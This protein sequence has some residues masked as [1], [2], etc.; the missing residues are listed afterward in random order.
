[1]GFVY[2]IFDIWSGNNAI[3]NCK[4]YCAALTMGGN[5]TFLQTTFANYFNQDGGRG[6]QPCVH[7]DNFDGTDSWPFIDSLFF[8]NCIIDGSQSGE[9]EMDIRPNT[10]NPTPVCKVT[11]CLIK[12]SIP[13]NT[14]IVNTNNVFNGNAD[15]ANPSTYD[16]KINGGSAAKILADYSL[17]SPA[18][19]SI[20]DKDITGTVVRPGTG[21]TSSGAYQFP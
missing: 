17:I 3:V 14:L 2:T 16:F 20:L 4:E 19:L 15:F 12:G 9:L 13:T 21:A 8:G 11:N 10:I 6:G 1:M 7:V 18:Y 5:Y